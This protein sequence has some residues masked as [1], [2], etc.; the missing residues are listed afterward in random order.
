ST[1][2]RNPGDLSQWIWRVVESHVEGTSGAAWNHLLYQYDGYG[3]VVQVSG[4]LSGTLPLDRFHE[5]P[6]AAVAAAP[7][8][9]SV[10]GTILLSKIAYDTQGN[11]TSTRGANGRCMHADYDKNYG[12]LPLTQASYVGTAGPNGCGSIYVPTT[13]TYDR[14]LG[15]VLTTKGPH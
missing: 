6:T 10:D 11:W 4:Q 15:A 5:D 13:A 14:G 1:W 12:Q 2:G 9:Q 7:A 3:D 8:T